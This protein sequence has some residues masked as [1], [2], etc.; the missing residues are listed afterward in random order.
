MAAF[1]RAASELR[2]GLSRVVPSDGAWISEFVPKAVAKDGLTTQWS[3]PRQ[4]QP[5][6]Q[7]H[8]PWR[9][10]SP[11][12]FDKKTDGYGFAVRQRCMVVAP[13]GGRERRVP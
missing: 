12:A 11:R 13:S 9:G 5:V 4:W 6:L 8:R 1:V 10:G 2:R 7:D 3:R